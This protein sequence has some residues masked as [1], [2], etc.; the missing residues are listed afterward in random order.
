LH[1]AQIKAPIATQRKQQPLTWAQAAIIVAGAM[2]ILVIGSGGREHALVWRLR[3]SPSV[4]KIWCAPGNGGIAQDAECVTAD[5]GNIAGLA[6]LAA[7][8]AVDLTVVGPEQPL[9]LG[10]A[11]EFARR[12][13]RLVGPSKRCAQLEGSKIFAKD[14]LERHSIPTAHRYAVCQSASE[15]YRALESIDHPL[16]MKAD[17]LCAGKGVLVTGSRNEARTFVE[18]VMERRELGEGG[19]MMLLEE[20][21]QGQ[22]L[23]F[24]VLTD[25]EHFVP[26][27]PTRDHKRAFDHDQGPNTGGMGAYSLDGIVSP[28]LEER[29]LQ[30]IV[31]P[32]FKGFAADGLAYR[33]FLYFGLMLTDGGPKVLE[34]NCRLGDPETQAIMARM[35]FDLVE[36]LAA[37]VE[38]SLNRVRIA[39]RPAAS[40]CVVLVSG[41]YPG[42]YEVGKKIEG[43]AEAG[44]IRGSI[45]FHAGT[46]YR[47][48]VYYTCSGRILGVS[49]AGQDL[50]AARRAAYDSI[51]KIQF[52]GM[53]YRSDIGVLPSKTTSVKGD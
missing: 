49:A 43:L 18:R 31:F 11:D 17:G 26:L 5:V 47:Q 36:V 6:E 1:P 19:K 23:S 27:A 35:D 4:E 41:G 46:E 44:K 16:V 3:R 51:G 13:L 2:K 33:G 20:A 7:R 37:A 30:T 28:E 39:W 52:D 29:I 53:R 12:G 42:R 21:L 10:I 14:F 24:I 15:A 38:G 45:V 40:V 32:T 9:V 48:N 25:G 50:E 8:L 22:E 34:F